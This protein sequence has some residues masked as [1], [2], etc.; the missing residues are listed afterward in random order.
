MIVPHKLEKK[1]C[2]KYLGIFFFFGGVRGRTHS[3][4]GNTLAWV[5]PWQKKRQER[6][7]QST[8]LLQRIQANCNQNRSKEGY[9]YPWKRTENSWKQLCCDAYFQE[10][11][12]LHVTRSPFP[13]WLYGGPFLYRRFQVQSITVTGP[14]F[15]NSFIQGPKV[16]LAPWVA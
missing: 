13:N 15:F 2:Y 12:S 10:T 16:M 6:N 5:L 8:I 4:N 1:W 11:W 7:S 9:W 3:N 14:S